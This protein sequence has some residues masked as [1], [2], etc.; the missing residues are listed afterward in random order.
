MTE[1][2]VGMRTTILYLQ[3]MGG[4]S[5]LR[6]DVDNPNILLEISSYYFYNLTE[7]PHLCVCLWPATFMLNGDNSIFSIHVL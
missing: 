6:S 7:L 3:S 1:F 5:D 2:V 4:P